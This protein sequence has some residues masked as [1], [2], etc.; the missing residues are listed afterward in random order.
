MAIEET[1]H[2]LHRGFSLAEGPVWDETGQALFFVDIENNAL[3][4]SDTR[5][6]LKSWRF[7][8][9]VGCIVLTEDGGAV[10]AAGS[11]IERLDLGTGDR[12]TLLD[13]GFPD[14]VRFNDGKC[15]PS[16]RL[17]AGSMARGQAHPKAKGC[18][19]LLCIE[20]GKLLADY[21]GFTIANGMDWSADGRVFYHIDTALQTVF[22]YDVEEGI[23]L[24]NRREAVVFEPGEGSPDG[25]C[26]DS[27]GMLWTAMWGAGCVR[28][29][30]PETGHRL[31]EIRL[32]DRY[33]SCC[34]FGGPGLETLFVTTAK[35]DDGR[36]GGVYSIHTGVKGRAPFLYKER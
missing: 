35:E 12:Q 31:A 10:A 36:L 29:V 3:Y 27:E 32:P 18:G 20:K 1:L 21:G 8:D 23:H 19:R 34:A 30:N 5:G 7:P 13:C 14:F 15:D 9:M 6:G 28:R 17:W 26:M 33:V 16:G 2:L 11:R 25:M 24:K 4:R 22:R